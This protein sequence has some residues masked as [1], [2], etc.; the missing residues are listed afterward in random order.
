MQAGKAGLGG[1]VA[2]ARRARTQQDSMPQAQVVCLSIA[3]RIDL[4]F[5][6]SAGSIVQCEENY[7]IYVDKNGYTVSKVH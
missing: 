7:Y 4:S 2:G 1:Y 5:F 6:A 3:Q